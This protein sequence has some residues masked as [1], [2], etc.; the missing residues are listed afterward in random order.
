[1]GTDLAEGSEL[2]PSAHQRK[3][4]KVI[5]FVPQNPGKAQEVQSTHFS[6]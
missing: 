6:R 2:K 3:P 5:A 1:M 4:T